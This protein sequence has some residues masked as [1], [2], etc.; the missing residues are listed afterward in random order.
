MV[1][2][3]IKTSVPHLPVITG[4]RLCWSAGCEGKALCF[5][6]SGRL[7]LSW[8]WAVAV[9]FTRRP[10]GGS[11]VTLSEQLRELGE[12]V[13]HAACFGSICAL[14]EYSKWHHRSVHTN[15]E[16]LWLQKVCHYLAASGIFLWRIMCFAFYEDGGKKK[17]IRAFVKPQSPLGE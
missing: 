15:T 17:K 2:F 12:D 4:R 6:R 3:R 11:N 10:N 1:A 16:P 9:H 14:S 5:M 8:I 7:E 13:L